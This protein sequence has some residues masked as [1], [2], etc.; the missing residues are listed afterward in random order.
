MISNDGQTSGFWPP[1]LMLKQ[2][3][4]DEFCRAKECKNRMQTKVTT[5]TGRTS[6]KK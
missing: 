1:K 5:Q 6:S 2:N 3:I 4:S